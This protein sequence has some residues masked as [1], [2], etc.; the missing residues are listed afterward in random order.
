MNKRMY[1]LSIVIVLI[2]SV[3]VLYKYL[4]SSSI[5]DENTN[6][7]A[8]GAENKKKDNGVTV[9]VGDAVVGAD[10]ADTSLKRM[11]GLSGR[12]SLGDGEGMLFVYDKSGIYTFW[13]PDMNFAIDIIW[14]S[15]DGKVVHIKENARPE[16]YPEKYTPLEYARYVLEVPSGYV[17]KN[18]IEIGSKVEIIK[19]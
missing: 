12:V 18:N 1:A 4:N 9:K 5:V 14:I 16:D 19:E 3:S 13:M 8:S 11:K 7:Q 15:G 17:K 10:I 2:L 6:V